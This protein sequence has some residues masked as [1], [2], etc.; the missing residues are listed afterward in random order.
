M[1]TWTYFH[2]LD[3]FIIHFTGNIGLRWY[4]MAYILGILAGWFCIK[5][6]S[7]KQA[8]A[9][10][11]KEL[12][13]FVVYI[14]F[15]IIL[16]G[17]IGYAVFYSPDIL[18]SFDS[19][20]PYW[21]L[22]KIH[23]GGLASHGGIIGIIVAALWFAKKR[24]FSVYHCLDL[25]AVG[26]IGIFFGRIANFI[27]GELFGR[28]VQN[29]VLWAVQFPQEM[30]LWVSEKKTEQLNAL[31]SA[32]YQ[33]KNSISAD[34]WRDW[35]SQID[36]VGR[37]PIYSAVYALIKACEEGN[38][39]VIAA[40]KSTLSLRH[41]SQVYQGILEGLL[42]FLVVLFL[43][44]NRQKK[45]LRP[46]L[47]GGVWVV[48]YSLMRIVGEQFRTPDSHIGFQ[49]LGWTRGQWLSLLTL[50]GITIYFVMVFKN[51]DTRLK[52]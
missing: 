38:K 4:S 48:C 9:L 7:Q 49:A 51:K 13:D 8:I 1:A 33:L 21:E 44:Y 26:T 35:V 2:N 34:V 41:P 18:T 29:K 10:S 36:G 24:G 32:V 46:G 15:G 42:P 20:F 5:R 22:L 31:S 43:F 40:L 47:I 12:S 27:N 23:Q 14:A 17:R 37:K 39:E 25:T 52:Y 3:P 11:A 45:S 19:Q 28:V 6:L 16:G 50:V 30:F